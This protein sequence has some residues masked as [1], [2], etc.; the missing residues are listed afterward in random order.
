MTNGICGS[1]LNAYLLGRDRPTFLSEQEA[2]LSAPGF[3]GPWGRDRAELMRRLDSRRSWYD[4]IAASRR[5]TWLEPIHA[6]CG[7]HRAHRPPGDKT[8]WTVRQDGPFWVI[9]EY[10]SQSKSLTKQR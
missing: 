7:C 3:Q 9:W 6:T 1:R 4:R 10:R 5:F 8:L 2:A